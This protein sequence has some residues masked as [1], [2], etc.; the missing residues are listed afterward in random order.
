M[1]SPWLRC[2]RDYHKYWRI[3]LK[4]NCLLL[5]PDLRTYRDGLQLDEIAIPE[6]D[7]FDG[8]EIDS[9]CWE[10]CVFIRNSK[11]IPVELI[12]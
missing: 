8:V 9:G 6:L 1:M 5:Y 12:V 2:V 7:F 10:A 11:F 3:C 4:L